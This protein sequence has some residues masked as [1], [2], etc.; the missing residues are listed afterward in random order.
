MTGRKLVVASLLLAALVAAP[1]AEASRRSS[2]A[3]NLLFEDFKD[4]FIFPHEVTQYVNHVWFDF[5]TGAFTV[6]GIEG[7]VDGNGGSGNGEYPYDAKQPGVGNPHLGSGGIMVG[8]A[9]SRNFGIGV[10]VHRA[11]YQGALWDN[12]IGFGRLG[13]FLS[14]VANT[15]YENRQSAWTGGDGFVGLTEALDALNWLDLLLGFEVSPMIDLGARLSIASDRE[16]RSDRDGDLEGEVNPGASATSFNL[17]ASMG[18]G[19]EQDTF[20]MDLGVEL[21]FASYSSEWLVGDDGYTDR[22]GAFGLGLLGRGFINMSESIAIGLMAEIGY[23]SRSTELDD[24][25]DTRLEM[26]G[27]DLLIQL[28]AGPRYQITEEATVGAYLNLGLLQQTIDPE[29]RDN[30]QSDVYYFLPGI[31]I[32]G[33]FQLKRWLTYRA[34]LSSFYALISGER[35]VDSDSGGSNTSD[36]DI[37]FYWSTGIGLNALDGD[38]TF[39]CM[40]NWPIITAGPSILSGKSNDMFAMVTAGYTF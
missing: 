22:G 37:F 10:A 35:Q 8:N 1:V 9:V 17:L 27:A 16:T 26:S 11:D 32:A 4:V 15:A 28:A 38:F 14:L 6:P 21:T 31:N 2:L 3:G 39:D 5:V 36:R 34:G 24:P 18:Y 23:K 19:A 12:T 29:G 40:L 30:V 20:Y 25:G 33:E 13:D 7:I